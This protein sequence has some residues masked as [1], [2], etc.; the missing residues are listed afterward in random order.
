MTMHFEFFSTRGA[1]S[2]WYGLHFDGNIVYHSF[3][4]DVSDLPLLMTSLIQMDAQEAS[5]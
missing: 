4:V 1:W 5:K 3:P 2:F